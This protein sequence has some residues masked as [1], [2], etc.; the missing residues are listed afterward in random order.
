[1]KTV[2]YTMESVESD[3]ETESAPVAETVA[4]E[5]QEEEQE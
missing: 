4:E 1:M 2:Y 3:R 5:V